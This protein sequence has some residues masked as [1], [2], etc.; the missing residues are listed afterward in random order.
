MGI[1]KSK[2]EFLFVDDLAEACVFVMNLDNTEFK[3]AINDGNHFFNVG[4]GEEISIRELAKKFLKLLDIM[5]TWFLICLCQ[6]EPQENFWIAA[7]LKN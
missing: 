1:W 4:S 3:K 5:E 2:R 7:K 6:T